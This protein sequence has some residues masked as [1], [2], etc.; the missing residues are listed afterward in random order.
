VLL[1]L[2]HGLVDVRDDEDGVVH[3][4]SIDNHVLDI[5]N[6]VG[7]IDVGVV[8]GLDGDKG[9]HGG[10]WR[11]TKEQREVADGDYLGQLEG[12]RRRAQGRG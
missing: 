1:G 3:L 9:G 10:R 7:A 8:A 5:V 11:N 6:M 12:G 2:R 4:R